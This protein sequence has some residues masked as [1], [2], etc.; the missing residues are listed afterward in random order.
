M[1]DGSAFRAWFGRIA[2][3]V[4]NVSGSAS[5]FAIA[6]VLIVVWVT[7]GPVFGFSDTW[8]LM[9]NTF[10]TL[11]TFLMVFLIQNTQNRDAKATQLK[12]DEL[13]RA[14]A[15]ARNQFIGAELEPE[16]RIEREMREIEAQKDE[17]SGPPQAARSPS[18]NGEPAEHR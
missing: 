17:P 2:T 18:H 1:T 11:V 13:I 4:S 6:I 5:A 15:D 12:L 16:E 9:A 14:I 8:Q 7:T 10:T 3:R